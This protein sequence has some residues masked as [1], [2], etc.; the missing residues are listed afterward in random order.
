[1]VLSPRSQQALLSL[2]AFRG[3]GEAEREKTRVAD[4]AQREPAMRGRVT[5]ASVGD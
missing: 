1:M 5:A 3:L 2:P 4:L